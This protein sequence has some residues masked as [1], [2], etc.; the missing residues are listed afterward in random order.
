[1]NE[2]IDKVEELKEEIDSL[3][4][5]I[6]LKELNEKIMLDKDLLKDI[7]EY[8]KTQDENIKERIINNKLFREYKHKETDCNLLIMEINQKLKEINNRNKGCI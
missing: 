1:M 2:L 3:D 8:N 7:E 6:E 4:E 5:I